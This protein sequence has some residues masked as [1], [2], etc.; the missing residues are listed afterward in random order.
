[1]DH[2]R[3]GG[4]EPGADPAA[5]AGRIQDFIFARELAEVYLLLDNVSASTSKR[6]PG[7]GAAA[8]AAGPAQDLIAQICAI[9]WPPKGSDLEQAEQAAILMRARDQLNIY[10]APATGSTI[11]F[12][13]LVAGEDRPRTGAWL[14]GLR[15]VWNAL[16]GSPTSEEEEEAS[17]T[18]PWT[19]EEWRRRPPTRTSLAAW[20]FPNL[21]PR[22][23]SFRG[24]MRLIIAGLFVWLIWTCL[25]SWN[26][27]TGNAFMTQLT[28]AVAAHDKVTDLITAETARQA[29]DLSGP[30]DAAGAA[31]ASAS[32]APSGPFYA[33]CEAPKLL[34]TETAPDG[35]VIQ[36]YHSATEQRIC[37]QEARTRADVDAAHA[38]IAQWLT[39][40]RWTRCLPE[41]LFG[42]R[43]DPRPFSEEAYEQWAATL[44]GV[45]GG[46][47]L[48]ICFGL[49]GAGAAV[50]RSL[51]AR[52]RDSLL[53]P[54]DLILSLVQLALGAVIGGCI[55]LFVTP[56]GTSDADKQ[57]LLGSVPLSASAL[58]F[59]AGFGVESVFLALEGLL[60]RVFNAVEPQRPAP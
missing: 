20:A 33:Y 5:Q 36:R 30:Q 39:S 56:A 55:G 40:W 28:N 7:G 17:D 6:L 35:S 23:A 34:G 51:S 53:S 8:Q 37:E 16:G 49:L 15:R 48:P 50:V 58:C 2:D 44:L 52:M 47:V 42:R 32:A 9:G 27:A 14:R 54:R 1:M 22:A 11:A 60:K 59:I 25:L 3:G 46:A 19:G 43:C 31:P 18:P 4:R 41:S 10:A 24:W 45:L 38:N 57:G 26:V 29:A 12:T 21:A 13:L